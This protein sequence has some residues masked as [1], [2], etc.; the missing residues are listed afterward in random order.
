LNGLLVYYFTD[1]GNLRQVLSDAFSLNLT[2]LE[3]ESASSANSSRTL[4]AEWGT[5]GKVSH[6]IS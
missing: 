5:K 6:S 2:D 1:S 3:A 4:I